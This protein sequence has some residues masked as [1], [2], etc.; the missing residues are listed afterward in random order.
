MEIRLD[1]DGVVVINPLF[2]QSFKQE[3]Y[4]SMK[5]LISEKYFEFIEDNPY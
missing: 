1:K 4:N 3:K 5:D 2:K